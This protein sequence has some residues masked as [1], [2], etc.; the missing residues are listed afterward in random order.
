MSA[1]QS[2]SGAAGAKSRRT[3]PRARCAAGSAMVVR[4]TLPRT[5]PCKPVSRH[6]PLDGA[7]RHRDAFP[8]E[9]RAT[10]SGRR[11]RRSS[12]RGPGESRSSSTLVALRP[13]GSAGLSSVLVVRRWGDLQAVLQQHGTDR[14]DTPA[15]ATGVPVVGVPA[16][17]LHDQR[18]GRS[19]SA[20]KKARG[21]LQDRVSPA[22]LG[23]LPRSRL[24]SAASSVVVPARA[25][26]RPGPA[27]PTC[28][29]SR[30]WRP[31]A[32]RRPGPSPPSPFRGRGGSPRTSAPPAPSA[33]ADTS[34]TCSLT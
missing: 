26:H 14:L 34:W 13:G 1:T 17:E 7:P 2:R 11:T 18:E 20:A 8:V 12:P 27:G 32:D 5:A 22:Q 16:D 10:L 25:P 15:Q 33:Q 28:G 21:R 29:P 3:R 9:L 23:V 31:R 24:I 6:Q 30:R 4:L 19:S